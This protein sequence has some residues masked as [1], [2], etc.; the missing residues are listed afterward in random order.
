M[1]VLSLRFFGATRQCA[2]RCA[3]A[4][5]SRAAGLR[6]ETAPSRK[7]HHAAAETRIP[8]GRSCAVPL[9]TAAPLR[10]RRDL[11]AAAAP[12][13]RL[14]RARSPPPRTRAPGET[15]CE[16]AAAW[17]HSKRHAKVIAG[18]RW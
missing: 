8:F 10:T 6:A 13:N 12:G 5:T 14:H 4:N 1:Q 11:A 9:D 2:G 15:E 16:P 3:A 7:F 17:R 18:V